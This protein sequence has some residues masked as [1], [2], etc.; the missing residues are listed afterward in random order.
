MPDSPQ[1]RLRPSWDEYFMEL[2]Y[3]VS[4]RST[5]ISRQVGA[6]VVKEKRIMTTGYNGAPSGIE[7]CLDRGYCLRRR[8][9]IQSGQHLE[10]CRGSHAEENAIVQAAK[11]GICLAGGTIYCT[12]RPCLICSKMLINAGIK[13]AV[14]KGDYPHDMGKEMFEEAGV[15]LVNFDGYIAGMDSGQPGLWDLK[16]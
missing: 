10:L 15:E 8:M 13:K 9:D 14:Y 11:F 16:R 7:S 2:A 5:C 4:K 3:V 6:V 12:H 1:K